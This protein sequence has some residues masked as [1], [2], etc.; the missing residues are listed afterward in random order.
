MA[1]TEDTTL[2]QSKQVSAMDTYEDMSTSNNSVASTSDEL[3]EPDEFD[4][5][6][7]MIEQWCTTVDANRDG[8]IVKEEVMAQKL[9]VDIFFGHLDVSPKDGE[10]SL[11]ECLEDKKHWFDKPVLIQKAGFCWPCHLKRGCFPCCSC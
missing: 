2:L 4:Q 8:R 1:G 7:N 10:V 9:D 3:E 6:E 11:M 5:G